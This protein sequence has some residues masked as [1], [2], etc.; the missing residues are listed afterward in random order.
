MNQHASSS[1]SKTKTSDNV[2]ATSKGPSST[3]TE[4]DQDAWAKSNAKE[5]LRVIMDWKRAG[6]AP[7]DCPETLTRY[8]ATEGTDEDLYYNL[9]SERIGREKMVALTGSQGSHL[10]EIWPFTYAP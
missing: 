10:Q 2:I 8:H 6:T 7:C 3:S 9:V 4:L 1:H 5:L